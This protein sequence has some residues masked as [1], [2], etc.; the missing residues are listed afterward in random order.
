MVIEIFADGLDREH[1]NHENH[2]RACRAVILREGKILGEY[3]ASRDVFNLPG[4]GWEPSETAE[5]CCRR[6][7]REETGLEI[8]SMFPTVTV[9]EY[10]PEATFETRYFRCDVLATLPQAPQRTEQE[11]ADG[12][13]SQWYDLYDFLERLE[14]YE[15]R[16]PF[17]ANIH[18]RDLIGLL[19]SI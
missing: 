14:T 2:R 8:A 4:G 13:Q 19:N 15:S 16:D 7:V 17:G 3:F 12:L 6:E 18:Q 10:F 11:K 5:D 1:V 9:I